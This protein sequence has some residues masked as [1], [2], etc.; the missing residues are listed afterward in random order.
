MRAAG[1][2]SGSRWRTVVRFAVPIVFLAV[3]AVGLVGALRTQDWSLAIT[4]LQPDNL[5]L[6]GAAFAANSVA[7]VFS[8]LAW[9]ALLVDL[10]GP[11]DTVTSARIYF[12]GFLAK[13]APGRFWPLLANIR[14]G[15]AAGVTGP[16]MATVYVLSMVISSLVGLTVG[17]AAAPA[18][19][20][21]ATLALA[22][23][24]LPVA[25]GLIRP[26]LVNQAARGAARLFRRPAPQVAASNAGLRRSIVAQLF[27]WLAAGVQLWLLAIAQ[28]ASPL[29]ALPIGVGAFALATVA[30]VAVVLAPDGLGVREGILLVA[31][32]TVLPLPAAGIVVIAS[33]LVCTLSEI[34]AAGAALLLAEVVKRRQYHY[35]SAR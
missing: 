35:A 4:L 24:A 23:A 27:C 3:V 22:L 1:Q 29:P 20:G 19:L 8:W 11:V 30:G 25:A 34:A 16:R 9:R 5:G 15:S 13:F 21:A 31:L 32:A 28:G 7:M 2:R 6:V 18:V 10:G 12:V 33:R 14:M 26:D 17:L